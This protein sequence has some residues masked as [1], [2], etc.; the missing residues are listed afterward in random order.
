MKTTILVGLLVAVLAS[1]AAALSIRDFNAKPPAEQSSYLSSFVERMSADLG[2][3]RPE[4]TTEIRR[5]FY[6][7]TPEGKV[8]SEG[9]DT[10]YAELLAIELRARD[11]KADLS[12]IEIESVIVWVV[13]Q[14]FPPE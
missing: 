13:K 2:R 12:K 7:R 9:L 1:P 8:V 3:I 10:L 6:H 11:G 14:R 4:L 5:Y